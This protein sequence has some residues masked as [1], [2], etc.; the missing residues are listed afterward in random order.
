MLTEVSQLTSWFQNFETSAPD[1]FY[2]AKTG[3]YNSISKPEE[4][5]NAFS[6]WNKVEE[7]SFSSAQNLLIK[8][9]PHK[10]SPKI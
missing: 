5:E 6:S 1:E 3:H 8:I 4:P 2:V 7:I 9:V 10:L